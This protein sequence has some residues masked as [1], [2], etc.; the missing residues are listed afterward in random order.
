M[1]KE[2]LYPNQV[3]KILRVILKEKIPV[4]LWGPPGIGKSSLVKQICEEWE[5]PMVDLRLSLKLRGG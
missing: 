3:K 2:T 4:F 5:A 1:K